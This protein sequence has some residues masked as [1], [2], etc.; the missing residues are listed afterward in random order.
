[1]SINS[2]S[3]FLDY[4]EPQEKPLLLQTVTDDA[5]LLWAQRAFNDFNKK[6]GKNASVKQKA[7]VSS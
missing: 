6:V 2:C 5:V 1:M 3:L 7:W 4:N